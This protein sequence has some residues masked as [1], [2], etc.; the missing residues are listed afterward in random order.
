MAVNKKKVG[1]ANYA[2]LI[3]EFSKIKYPLGVKAAIFPEH[4]VPRLALR[5]GN[6]TD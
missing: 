4:H 1:S 3:V 2:L 6:L 5:I